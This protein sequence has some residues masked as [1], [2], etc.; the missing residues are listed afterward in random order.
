MNISFFCA[1]TKYLASHRLYLISKLRESGFEINIFGDPSFAHKKIFRNCEYIGF[2]FNRN[3]FNKFYTIRNFISSHERRWADVIYVVGMEAILSITVARLVSSLMFWNKTRPQTYIFAVSGLGNVFQY[4]HSFSSFLIY[5]LAVSTIRLSTNFSRTTWLF[6]SV[7]DEQVLESLVEADLNSRVIGGVGVTIPTN[8]SARTTERLV[9]MAG[10]IIEAKGVQDFLEVARV[11]KAR[12][13]GWR[14]IWAGAAEKE[15]PFSFSDWSLNELN[16]DSVVEF[17]GEVESLGDLLNKAFVVAF[18]SHGEGVS[19]FLSEAL[20]HQVPVIAFRVRGVKSMI[21]DGETGLLVDK[22]DIPAMAECILRIGEDAELR[23]RLVENGLDYAKSN[24]SLKKQVARNVEAIHASITSDSNWCGKRILFFVAVDWYFLSHRVDLASHFI[25]QGA[26]V[27]FVGSVSPQNFKRFGDPGIQVHKIDVDRHSLSFFALT[28]SLI[29]ILRVFWVLKPE[30]IFSVSFK[31]IFLSS[32]LSL[33]FK[34][35]FVNAVPGLGVAYRYSNADHFGYSLEEDRIYRR[36]KKSFSYIRALYFW[37]DSGVWLFQ[38]KRDEQFVVQELGVSPLSTRQV[39][40]MGAEASRSKSI[41]DKS[42]EVECRK[43]LEVVLPA[44]MVWEKGIDTFFKIALVCYAKRLNVRFTLCGRLEETG[45]KTI[46]RQWLDNASNLPNLNYIGN[47]PDVWSGETQF[48]VCLLPTRYGEGF[49][50][51]LM[52]AALNGLC[53]ITSSEI[54][55]HSRVGDID[56][57]WFHFSPS[58]IVPI[59]GLLELFCS[60]P[61]LLNRSKIKTSR[62]AFSNFDNSNVLE[63]IEHAYTGYR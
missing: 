43:P 42:F 46:P 48:D 22:S 55:R 60:Q 15:S 11:I 63:Q 41:I 16:Y 9:L 5:K 6:Q 61:S 2:D 19:K 33:F 26:E 59:V 31:P 4:R 28:I 24:L 62:S 23:A 21:A 29:N 35:Y 17:V 44:R 39:P 25:R 37:R 13:P 51:V 10:R 54:S 18:T 3:R 27:H 57:G 45:P 49:P 20:A 52:E 53:I 47:L 12:S 58:D 36:V 7:E 34:G 56:T 8:R 14:F 1:S 30:F 40:G 32:I 50:K 38:N